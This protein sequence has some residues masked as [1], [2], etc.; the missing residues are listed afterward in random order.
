MNKKR[1]FVTVAAWTLMQ[2]IL[3]FAAVPDGG[4]GPEFSPLTALLVVLGVF[5]IG[6]I[7]RK[8]LSK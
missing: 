2:S 4:G 7:I 1:L 5:I 3:A 8:R 6:A